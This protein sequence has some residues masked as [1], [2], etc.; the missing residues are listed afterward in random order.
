M[1]NIVF[2]LFVLFCCYFEM[3]CDHIIK[4][5]VMFIW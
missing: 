1:Q 3:Q 2:Y 5:V 4:M